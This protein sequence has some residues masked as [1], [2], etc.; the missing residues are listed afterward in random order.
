MTTVGFEQELNNA[1]DEAQE[2]SGLWT[3]TPIADKIDIEMNALLEGV[4]NGDAEEVTYELLP[5]LKE[6]LK[7]ADRELQIAEG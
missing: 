6:T 3:N 5:T 7:F 2:L 4:K 1:L